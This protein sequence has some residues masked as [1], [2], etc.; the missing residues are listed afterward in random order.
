MNKMAG[1]AILAASV[2]AIGLGA[3]AY[4]W[5]AAGPAGPQVAIANYSFSPASMT[6]K[7]GTTVRWVN[8][9]GIEHTVTFGDQNGM[10]NMGSGMMGHMG[11][12][13]YTFMQPGTYQYHCTPHPYMTGTVTVTP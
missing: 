13:G 4:R 8:M 12:Y 3:L 9:D 10:A 6:V 5:Q 2:L 1:F 11:S 7:A